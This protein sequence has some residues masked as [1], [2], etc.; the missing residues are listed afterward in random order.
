MVITYIVVTV[1]V[2]IANA[3]S[4]ALDFGRYRKILIAMAKA[5]PR[6]FNRLL[7]LL[8]RCLV[9]SA[10]GNTR[11][12]RASVAR[13]ELT[14]ALESLLAEAQRTC[15]NETDSRWNVCGNMSITPLAASV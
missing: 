1:L 11:T 2:A 4:A 13:H 15:S 9:L 7:R 6:R 8:F 14:P 10:T 3:F 12:R 5:Q